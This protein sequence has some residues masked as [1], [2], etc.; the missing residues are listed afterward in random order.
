MPDEFETRARASLA[1]F[2]DPGEALRGV[3][4]GVHQKTFSGQ[5]YATGVTDQRLLLLPVGRHIEAKGSPMVVTPDA[6]AAVKLDGAGDGWW[7]APMA[8]L[9]ATSVTLHLGTR[10]G[11]KLK[12]MMMLGGN[13]LMG[14][15]GGGESKRNGVLALAEWLSANAAARR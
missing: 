10:D 4:A 2:V 15:L 13:G 5:L 8:V 3:A 1:P 14:S 12:L 7:T 6:I 11:Q 9:D